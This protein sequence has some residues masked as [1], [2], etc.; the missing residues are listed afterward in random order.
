MHQCFDEVFHNMRK[1]TEFNLYCVELLNFLARTVAV[2]VGSVR[3]LQNVVT[4]TYKLHYERLV[5]TF[6]LTQF[7]IFILNLH[8]YIFN[9]SKFYVFG[10]YGFYPEIP[11]F[12]D[13]MIIVSIL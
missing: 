9:I 8:D 5:V 11:R 12:G 1:Y 13:S 6:K 4:K 7:R 2:N 10:F 3:N